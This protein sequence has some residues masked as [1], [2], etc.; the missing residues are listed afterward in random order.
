MSDQLSIL[1]PLCSE[2]FVGPRSMPQECHHPMPTAAQLFFTVMKSQG[3]LYG[4]KIAYFYFLIH[5]KCFKVS[6]P[7]L[8]GCHLDHL[9]PVLLPKT[10]NQ[11]MRTKLQKPNSMSVFN[12]CNPLT[13]CNRPKIEAPKTS[14]NECFHKQKNINHIWYNQIWLLIQSDLRYCA[15]QTKKRNMLFSK[16]WAELW[17]KGLPIERK[18]I[19]KDIREVQTFGSKLSPDKLENLVNCVLHISTTYLR[20]TAPRCG[21]QTGDC[22]N[23]HNYLKRLLHVRKNKTPYRALHDSKE[24]KADT[25]TKC[26]TSIDPSK[27]A[28]V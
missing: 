3:L 24:S 18:K 15:K 14:W 2:A 28:K 4:W 21:K 20:C 1:P 5:H 26:R 27:R 19:R 17:T 8:Q 25:I 9:L 10:L 13:K 12:L 16:T 11:T 23:K 7:R 22:S 6:V